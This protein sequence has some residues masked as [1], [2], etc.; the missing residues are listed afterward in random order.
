MT[1]TDFIPWTMSKMR[2][3]EIEYAKRCEGPVV[4]FQGTLDEI[5]L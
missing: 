2:N 5:I 3:L 4:F 1:V